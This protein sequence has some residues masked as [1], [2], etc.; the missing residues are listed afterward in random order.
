MEPH[1]YKTL[2]EFESSYWWYKGLHHILLDTL[3]KL[4][5]DSD[6]RILDA[7]CGTGQNLANI[8]CRIAEDTYG[9]DVSRHAG[10]FWAKRGLHRVCLASI[11]EIPFPRETFDAVMSIDVLECDAVDE[12]TAYGELW[13]ILKPGGYLILVVP[14]YDWLMTPEHHKAVQASRR[15]SRSKLAA[16][17]KTRPL[18]LIRMTH[19]FGA[20]LPAIAAYRLG[21]RYLAKS[22]DGPPTSE[23]RPMHPVTNN[24][25]LGVMELERR[26]LRL[27]NLPFGS[28]IMA[29]ARRSQR[30]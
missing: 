6:A 20:L 27:W 13:R 26:Y 28:S 8:S 5:L 25:L 7:G 15:Y 4:P 9:F 3:G 30:Q 16:L 18:E 1:E 19:L 12:H 17:L 22:S 29:V 2:Y 23:L 14:A 21:L 24:L 11:N 10:P